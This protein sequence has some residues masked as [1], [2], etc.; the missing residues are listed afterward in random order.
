MIVDPTM[1]KR[2]LANL[3]TNALQAMPDGGKLTVTANMKQDEVHI[4][5]EDTG[6]GI[7]D[8]NRA[9][10]FKPLFSTKA[11]GQGFGLAVV[12]RLVEAHNGTIAFS[13][14]VGKGTKFTITIPVAKEA[15]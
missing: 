9:K 2:I 14:E 4:N 1:M 13:S 6:Q 8:E 11:K 7:P 5:V 3:I 10:V 12:K 15:H